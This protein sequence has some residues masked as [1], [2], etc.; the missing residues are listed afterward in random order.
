MSREALW[1]ALAEATDAVKAAVEE[2][3]RAPTPP[4][5][6]ARDAVCCE[7]VKR[8]SPVIGQVEAF[9]FEASLRAYQDVVDRVE[10][11]HATFSAAASLDD[12]DRTLVQQLVGERTAAGRAFEA[13]MAALTVA[14]QRAIAYDNERT[15]NGGV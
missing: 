11:L 8:L 12:A 15:E 10:Q 1:T 14:L 6:A 3:R 13:A 7:Y 5:R 9:A 4:A 2:Y